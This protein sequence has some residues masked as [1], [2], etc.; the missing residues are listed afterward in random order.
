MWEQLRR[1]EWARLTHAY[2]Y[3]HDVPK[4]LRRMVSSDTSERAAGWDAF[5]GSLNHQGDFYDSTVAVIPFLIDSLNYGDVPCREG[6]LDCLRQRW[7][8]APEY[9]GDPLASAPPGGI[10]EPTPMHTA[11]AG[12]E[13]STDDPDDD[14]SGGLKDFDSNAYRRMDLCAWQ[15]GRAIQAGRPMF[16]RLLEDSNRT[17]A[18]AAAKLLLLWPETRQIAK[19]NMVRLIE[20]EPDS[21]KQ[22]ECILEFGVY[23]DESDLPTLNRWI[24]PGGAAEMRAA[25]AL[26]WAWVADPRRVPEPVL[27]TLHDC[28]A[29][30]ATAFSDLPWV[31]VYHRGPWILPTTIAHIILR[32]AESE[33]K[34]L[35]WR[36]VQGLSTRRE[37]AKRLSAEQVIPV[38]MRA[39]DDRHYRVR[40]AAAYALSQRAEAVAAQNLVPALIDALEARGPTRWDASD[41]TASMSAATWVSDFEY[42][43]LDDG[44][45]ACGHIA[46]LLATLS[47]RLD[48]RQRQ[49]SV[50][51]VQSVIRHYAGR[52]AT[53]M[54]DTMGI[55]A[56]SLLREQL[57][58]LQAPPKRGLQ[59]LLIPFAFPNMQEARL[60]PEYCER[61]L[62]ELVAQDLNATI[63]DAV[64]VVRGAKNRN[65]AL[66]AVHWLMTL[67]PAAEFGLP[68][69]DGMAMGGLDHYA[70]DEAKRAADFIRKALA[71][72]PDVCPTSHSSSARHRVASM[73][74]LQPSNRLDLLCEAVKLLDD[75]DP[76]VRAGAAEVMAKWATAFP[77]SPEATRR[78]LNLLSD[79]TAV[80]V[81]I[82]GVFEFEGRLTHWRRERR[83]PRA[84]AL[85]ALFVMGHV[86]QGELFLLAML[87][88]TAHAALVT[89]Q[90]TI[91][92]RFP[93]EQWRR[94]AASAGGR[95]IAE[96]QIRSFRQAC[97]ER[98]WSER[99]WSSEAFAA[100]AELAAVIGRLS[101]RLV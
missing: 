85:R 101:G 15:T 7:L 37:T 52:R 78:L 35:R 91:P 61:R 77:E 43:S 66:G 82:S 57:D 42:S 99:S 79:E 60:S 5:W 8:D 30:A 62:A 26:T 59:E 24:I 46:R 74:G 72:E 80:E 81:G 4:I 55:D 96:P 56:V 27:S 69:I 41:T 100:E 36:A 65:A 9:G 40:D 90:Q 13:D 19:R 2:G 21:K 10:D 71:V 70:K 34:E 38:L 23:A 3:A 53:V 98:G 92:R 45:T 31:G 83:S 33:H 20:E 28:S 29:P 73:L 75:N 86:P 89:A 6:I 50:A 47:D 87:A 76:Y 48:L 54:F 1:V 32:M 64:A 49:Q 39:L 67:G 25:A 11:P 51:A 14:D 58:L 17:V 88:E 12:G 16:E 22:G 68:E 44:A 95:S 94:A 84:S 63:S 93:L 97:R 18:A